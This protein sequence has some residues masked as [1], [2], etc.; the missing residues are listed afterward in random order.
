[1]TPSGMNAFLM[2]C[3]ILCWIVGL[4]LFLRDD[5]DV[6]STIIVSESIYRSDI[7]SYARVILEPCHTSTSLSS[8]WSDF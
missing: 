4:F 1:M 7:G 2:D 5:E 8:N 3:V 6:S